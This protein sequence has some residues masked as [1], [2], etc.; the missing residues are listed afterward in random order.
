MTEYKTA[1][2][3]EDPLVQEFFDSRPISKGTKKNYLYRFI[4]YSNFTGKSPSELIDEA[5]KEEDSQIRN[6]HRKIKNY[7]NGFARHLET[8]EYKPGKK[9]SEITI[10]R[11]ITDIK[12]FYHFFDIDTPKLNLKPENPHRRDDLPTLD[13]IKKALR[14]I[15]T[16]DKA[17]ILLHLSSG[18]AGNEVRELKTETFIEGLGIPKNTPLG[19][20]RSVITENPIC[21]FW[22]I[23]IKENVEYVTFCSPQCV[24]AIVDYLEEKGSYSEYLFPSLIGGKMS[25]ASHVGIFTRIND[26]LGF[27][28]TANGKQRRFTSHKLRAVF[29]TNMYGAGVDWTKI[30]QM[31]GHTPNKL[32]RAYRRPPEEAYKEAYIEGL[33]SIT[34][35]KINILDFRSP[36]IQEIKNEN[37]ELKADLEQIK[38]KLAGL[39]DLAKVMD[40]PEV[41]KVMEEI[42]KSK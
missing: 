31:L 16:R 14:N 42:S 12:T 4:K 26:K 3:I 27:G 7:L 11:S 21:T 32:T 40:N 35:D 36:E 38:T 41:K 6:R 22:I 29:S 17:L 24:Y 25:Q 34:T 13:E 23:R 9:Y 30:D 33:D 8:I 18:M 1:D 15:N 10:G 20:L 19:E 39:G 5:E 37:L 28:L 2:I